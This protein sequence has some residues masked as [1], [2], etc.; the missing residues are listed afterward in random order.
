MLYKNV[1]LLCARHGIT[2]AELERRAGLSNGTISGW[3]VSVPKL[4]SISA[5]AEV[6]GIS[7]DDLTKKELIGEEVVS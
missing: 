1:K 4:N 2:I 5:V 3:A 7:I 6:F